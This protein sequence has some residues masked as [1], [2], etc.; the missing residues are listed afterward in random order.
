[1]SSSV[2]RSPRPSTPTV[3]RQSPPPTIPRQA[4]VSSFSASQ[5]REPDYLIIAIED[6]PLIREV[7]VSTFARIQMPIVCF[8]DGVEAIGAL[9]NGEVPV[10]DLLLLDIGLPNM[11]G[12]EVARILRMHPDFSETIIVMLTGH[13][14]PWNRV[15][16]RMIGAKDFIPKP[17]RPSQVI[18]IVCKHLHLELPGVTEGVDE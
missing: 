6:S 18:A 15:R 4:A 2:P 3:P 9:T 5:V 1:M 8:E 11:D 16:S 14:G 13:D 10:P 7:L 12:Y 17:F